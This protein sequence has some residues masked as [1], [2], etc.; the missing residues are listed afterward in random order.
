L[1]LLSRILFNLSGFNRSGAGHVSSDS[2]TTDDQAI[3]FLN[4]HRETL[5]LLLR[6]HQQIVTAAG[7]E[8]FRLIVSI[9]AMVVHKIPSEDLVSL[10]SDQAHS[11]GHQM[12]LAHS[13]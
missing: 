11:S 2:C 5:L 1:Q 8:E 3:S 6:E 10:I 7:I 4:A 13:T 12:A 9:L